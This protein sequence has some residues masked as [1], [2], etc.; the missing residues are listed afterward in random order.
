MMQKEETKMPTR[1]NAVY[2]MTVKTIP[3]NDKAVLKIQ[4]LESLQEVIFLQNLPKKDKTNTYP[5]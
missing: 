3:T 5:H 4:K 1:G 2:S